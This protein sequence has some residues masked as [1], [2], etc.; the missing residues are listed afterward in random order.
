MYVQKIFRKIF[1]QKC[2]IFEDFLR[3][4]ETF[5]GNREF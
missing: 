4:N 5:P 3:K 2:H 1:F